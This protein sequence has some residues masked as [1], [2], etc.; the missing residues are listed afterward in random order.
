M[1]FHGE[2]QYL[3]SRLT[4]TQVSCQ[5]GTKLAWILVFT[6][7][8]G[9][10]TLSCPSIKKTWVQ[11]PLNVGFTLLWCS[12]MSP[13]VKHGIVKLGTSVSS[14]S[15]FSSSLVMSRISWRHCWPLI[16]LYDQ[17]QMI[18]VVVLLLISVLLSLVLDENP[19]YIIVIHR[20][21]KHQRVV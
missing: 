3:Q 15:S 2:S 18:F 4:V 12:A 10:F 19:C 11:C 7:A 21:L 20:Y 17:L 16:N 8:V 9:L 13:E 1:C 5:N 14:L 6:T